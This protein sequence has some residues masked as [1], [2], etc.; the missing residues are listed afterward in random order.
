MPRTSATSVERGAGDPRLA[1]WR[2]EHAECEPG[3]ASARE[4]G[5]ARRSAVEQQEIERGGATNSSV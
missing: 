1:V 3:D 5:G 4:P 2:T